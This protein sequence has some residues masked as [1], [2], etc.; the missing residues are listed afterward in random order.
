MEFHIP[1]GYILDDFKVWGDPGKG[2]VL[3]RMY[4]ADF[5]DLSASDRQAYQLLENNSRLMLCSLRKG[6]RMQLQYYT[7]NDFARP[8]DRYA[9]ETA[10]STI[11]ICTAVR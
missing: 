5:P 1:T 4:A 2:C 11:A 9:S 7:S 6:E 3:S 8:L 10:K